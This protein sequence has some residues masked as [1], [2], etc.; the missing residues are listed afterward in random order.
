MKK[1]GTPSYCVL[2]GTEY[3]APPSHRDRR[4]FCSRA[5]KEKVQSEN[6]KR[7]L[8]ERFWEKVEKTET[9]WLWTGGLLKTGYGSIRDNGKAL[10]AHRV[11]YELLVGQIPDGMLLRHSCDNPKCVNPAHLIP[12]TAAQ[13]SQDALDRGRAIVGE[14]HHNAKIPNHAIATIRAALAAGVPGKY[15]AKQFGVDPTV[16]SRIKLNKKWKYV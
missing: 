9:C 1:E 16:I 4:Q 11:A 13:N 10:R 2:C 14:A 7:P 12:G 8:A 3:Y 5:C 15:L 6:M